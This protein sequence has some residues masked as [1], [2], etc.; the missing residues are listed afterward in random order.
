MSA[1]RHDAVRSTRGRALL[2]STARRTLTVLDFQLALPLP[3]AYIAF[4]DSAVALTF[5]DTPLL[6]SV[7][8]KVASFVAEY[9]EKSLL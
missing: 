6:A 9:W 1:L 8:V 5:A 7:L 4:V 2:N 3:F